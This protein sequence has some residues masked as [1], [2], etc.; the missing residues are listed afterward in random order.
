MSANDAALLG[1]AP[2]TASMEVVRR[3]F[4]PDGTL[5]LSG[6]IV[7]PADRFSLSM[8]FRRAGHG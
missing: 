7:Y 8:R 5:I 3:Y 2:G 4:D 1:V 6:R